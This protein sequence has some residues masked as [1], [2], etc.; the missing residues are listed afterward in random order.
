MKRIWLAA[1]MAAASV[2]LGV[3]YVDSGVSLTRCTDKLVPV[4][5][6]GKITG[7]RGCLLI[8]WPRSNFSQKKARYVS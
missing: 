1:A 5:M 6:H 7:I 4:Y 3:E 8:D 2:A